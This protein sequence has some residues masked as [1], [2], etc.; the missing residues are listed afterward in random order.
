MPQARKT[1]KK[2]SVLDRLKKYL[3][4]VWTELKRTTWP[5]RAEVLKSSGIVLVT[6]LFFIV[7]T[8]VVDNLSSPIIMWLAG[9]G[10]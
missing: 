1:A 5:S 10:R 4:D 8:F 2:P 3:R 7:L 9:L 6:L